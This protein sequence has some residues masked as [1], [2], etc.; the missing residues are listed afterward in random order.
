MTPHLAFKSQHCPQEW[1]VV[2]QGGVD[3]AAI[4]SG[5]AFPF[6]HPSWRAY[7]YHWAWLPW[8]KLPFSQEMRDLVLPHLSD[9]NFVQE[10]CDDLFNLFQVGVRRLYSEA[11]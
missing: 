2:S 1:G 5:L 9:M 8:V 3:V 7:P 4:D 6:K 10:L 11:K